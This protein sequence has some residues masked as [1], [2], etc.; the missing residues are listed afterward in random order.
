MKKYLSLLLM[1]LM[2]IMSCQKF[3]DSEIWDKLNDHEARIAYLEEVCKN[4]NTSIVNLQAVVTA[5]ET[6][7]YIVSASPLVTGDG[8]TIIFKSGKSIVIYNGKDGADGIDGEDGKD[9]AD[10]KDGQDGVTPVISVRQ[11]TDGYY[12]WTVDGEWL[13][14]NGEKVKAAAT[15]GKDGEDGE[16]GENGTN[17]A[18][19]VTP[20][21][22]IENDYWYVSYDNGNAWEKLGKATGNS[23]FNGI[24]GDDI[25]KRVFVEDGYVCFELNDE[26]K[27]IIRVPLMK[28]GVLTVNLEQEGT[29]SR[30][31]S[32]EQ[33]RTT[34]AL[35]LKGKVNED[36]MRYIQLMNNLQTLDLSDATY[37]RGENIYSI[38]DINPY[39]DTLINKTI[40]ELV[41]P[42]FTEVTQTNF[43]YCLAL[44]KLK[45]VNENTGLSDVEFC[46]HIS[47]LEYEEGQTMINE[48]GW[49]DYVPLDRIIYPNTM[50]SIPMSLTCFDYEESEL[51][52]S[53]SARI[54]HYYY[55]VP[56]KVFVCKAIVPP[57]MEDTRYTY[58]YN[59]K[60][61]SYYDKTWSSEPKQ[62]YRKVVVPS[63]VVLYVP[64]ESIEAYKKAPIWDNFTNILPLE[65]LEN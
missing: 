37:M 60:W 63:D 23:G 44:R 34:T 20:K 30:I 36:D 26:T 24:E 13:I 45:V 17:G 6:N 10:G 33:T 40:T 41:L 5:L 1:V 12:Y 15:D 57:V 31:L 8:Y 52:R 59:Q 35:I 19:G 27:T 51:T 32:S 54:Y 48:T 62:Y 65:S 22:K 14:V 50:K 3:D 25:F 39:K 4:M 11:D 64:S 29:L 49:D 61:Y 46:P 58:D 55:T 38:F 53:G 43:S 7:D 28:D 16:D 56:C 18:D 9:G 47:E 42:K 21:F 2:T